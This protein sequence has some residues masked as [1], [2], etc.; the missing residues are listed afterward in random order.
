MLM[1]N[2]GIVEFSVHQTKNNATHYDGKWYGTDTDPTTFHDGQWHYAVGTYHR[3]N[4]TLKMYMDGVLLETNDSEMNPNERLSDPPTNH[5]PIIGSASKYSGAR[6]NN[7]SGVIDEVAVYS[8]EL[9]A[10][11]IQQRYERG[12]SPANTP[13]L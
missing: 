6:P 7:Y 11:E 4:N 1:A 9:S 2:T 8:R 3:T 5:P 10:A 12:R 13:P